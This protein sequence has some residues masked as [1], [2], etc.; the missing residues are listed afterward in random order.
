MAP[1]LVPAIQA[2]LNLSD[3]EARTTQTFRPPT[4]RKPERKKAMSFKM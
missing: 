2:M 1:R 3:R 4:R